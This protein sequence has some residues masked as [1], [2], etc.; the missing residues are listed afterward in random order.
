MFD[1]KLFF[2]ALNKLF[3]RAPLGLSTMFPLYP[4][5]EA[6]HAVVRLVKIVVHIVEA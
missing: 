1:R 4:L 2:H 3:V 5:S 6:L